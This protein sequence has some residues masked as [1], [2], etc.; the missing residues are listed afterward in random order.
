LCEEIREETLQLS[1]T[2][3]VISEVFLIAPEEPA[4]HQLLG[5]GILSAAPTST[6][7]EEPKKGQIYYVIHPPS[8]IDHH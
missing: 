2:N 6:S 1:G 8:S 3:L 4:E 7:P 5:L